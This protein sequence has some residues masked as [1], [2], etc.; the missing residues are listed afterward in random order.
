MTLGHQIR[1]AGTTESLPMILLSSSLVLAKDDPERLF[2]A[3]IAA[4]SERVEVSVADNAGHDT[5]AAIART[6]LEVAPARF[7]L[8]GLSMGGY[9]AQ[10]VVLQAPER[11]DRLCLLDTRARPDVAEETAARHRLL[12][13]CAREGVASVQRMSVT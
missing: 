13:L 1:H 2:A 10:E 4:F 8:A 3:Q 5:M 6:I 9:I 7:C 12:D 11:V